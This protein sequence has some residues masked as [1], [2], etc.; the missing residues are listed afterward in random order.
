MHV[1]FYVQHLLGIGHVRRSALLTSALHRHGLEVTVVLGGRDVFGIDFGDVNIVRLPSAHVT[2]HTFKPLLDEYNNP[3]DETW[4]DRRCGILLDAFKKARPDVLLFE[5][6]PFGRRQ[7]RFELLPLIEAAKATTPRPLIISS[8]RDILVKK[9]KS[10]RTLESVDLAREHFDHV[11]VHGDETLV[12]LDDTLPEAYHIADLIR[13]TGYIA[14]P[15]YGATTTAGSD[16]VLVTA[17]GGAIGSRL[18]RAALAAKQN[19]KY[20]DKTWRFI[21]GPN[22]P[23]ADVRYLHENAPEGVIIETFRPDFPQMLVNCALS[24]SQGGYNTIMDLLRSKA[25]AI[26]APYDD[27]EES[28]QL[29]RTRLLADK[30]VLK[31][32]E[33]QYLTPETLCKAINE[34][35][36]FDFGSVDSINLTGAE[37]TAQMISELNTS[38][39]AAS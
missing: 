4:Q 26:V 33:S 38:P 31:V 29:Q 28:E 10:G 23:E 12:G 15:E 11:F 13:Y 24:I 34:I 6:Y 3:V 19:N 7:F 35:D 8:V 1:M 5:M 25:K 18:M 32:I 17:G 27:G 22:L 16:E 37:T 9:A 2:D 20:S 30:N 21:T 14:A 39:Q 36:E